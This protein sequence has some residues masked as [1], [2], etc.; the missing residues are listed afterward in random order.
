MKGVVFNSSETKAAAKR[1]VIDLNAKLAGEGVDRVKK[2][3]RQVLRHPSGYYESRI[4][5]QRRSVYRGIWDNNV[6]YGGWLEG[7]DPRN[8]TTKFKGYYTFMIVKH[9]LDQDKDRLLQP[10]M[11]KFINE[12][13]KK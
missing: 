9:T 4:E 7:V 6:P 5:V 11:D 12:M 10:I 1:M 8:R 13:N 2:H 3:L